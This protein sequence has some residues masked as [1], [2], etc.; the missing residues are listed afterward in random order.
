LISQASQILYIFIYWTKDWDYK[1]KL[2][3]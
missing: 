3:Y 2:H 1:I